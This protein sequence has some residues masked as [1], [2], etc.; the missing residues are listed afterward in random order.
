[1]HPTNIVHLTSTWPQLLLTVCLL[2]SSVTKN[3]T[4]DCP[5]RYSNRL[6]HT[7]YSL[8]GTLN[9]GIVVSLHKYQPG[10][11]CS[12]EVRALSHFQQLES[13]VFAIREIN[14]KKLI[15]PNAT[16]GFTIVDDC[17]N[18]ITAV[19]KALHFYINS[20]SCYNSYHA[21]GVEVL[22]IIQAS[23]SGRT[24]KM[25]DILSLSEIPQLSF[26]ATS[27]SLDNKQRYSN[28][29]RTVPSDVWQVSFFFFSDCA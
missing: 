23:S 16:L 28:F 10:V 7:D 11:L 2:F 27:Q 25:A 3:V 29:F 26:R 21:D 13:M 24:I 4:N 17:S 12:N 1:M 18:S 5:M 14:A 15:H 6:P 8:H 9:I 22:A 20:G 19:A